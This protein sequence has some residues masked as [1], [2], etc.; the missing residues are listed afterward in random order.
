[1]DVFYEGKPIFSSGSVSNAGTF[2]ISYGPGNSTTITIVMN[3]IT[4]ANSTTEWTYTPRI[5]S[6]EPSYFTFTENTN[7]AKVPIKFAFNNLPNDL[8][9]ETISDFQ[10]SPAG[11]YTNGQTVDVTWTGTS[12]QVNVVNDPSTAAPGASQ[13]LALATGGISNNVFVT[14][15][16]KYSLNYSYRGPGIVSWWRGEPATNAVDQL[17]FNN[18]SFLDEP[19]I[20]RRQG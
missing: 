1:M 19:F 5:V 10:G 3:Q 13:F 4:N 20:F 14:P 12:N 7:F 16:N 8:G 18:G 2:S 11:V 6:H 15:G 17:G 9:I